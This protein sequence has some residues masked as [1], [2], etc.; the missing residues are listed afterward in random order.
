[1]A[2]NSTTD[3][4]MARANK[5]RSGLRRASSLLGG[6]LLGTSIVTPI[7]AGGNA[8]DGDAFV[9]LLSGMLALA[10]IV[11]HVA[12]SGGTA[13]ARATAS[14]SSMRAPVHSQSA[15][16]SRDSSAGARMLV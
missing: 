5:K 4:T 15:R 12:G 8:V 14:M 11:V 16:V 13:H 2:M 3:V 10:G 9:I 1:M 7:L 6:A